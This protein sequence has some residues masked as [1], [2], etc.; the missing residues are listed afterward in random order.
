MEKEKITTNEA[1]EKKDKFTDAQN[2]VLRHPAGNLLVSASAG[3][4]KTSTL[5]EKIVRMVLAGDVK[6][7]NMLVVTFTNSASLELKEKLTTR[8]MES[9]DEKLIAEIDNISTSDIVT[10]D[11]FCIKVLREFG[12]TI[13]FNDNFS[14]ADESLAKFFKSQALDNIFA[15]HNKNLD[16]KFI[17]FVSQFFEDRKE[18][19]V[20]NSIVKLYNFLK[21]KGTG[22]SYSAMLDDFYK[23]DSNNPAIKYAN[24]CISNA[25]DAAIEL[26]EK[27]KLNAQI[28]GEEKLAEQLEVALAEFR[29]INTDILANFY[30]LVDLKLPSINADNKNDTAEASEIK[31]Q[32]AKTKAMFI[33]DL[34]SIL[35][36]SA[37][38][39]KFEQMQKD[40]NR[41]KASLEYVFDI[42]HEF[43]EEYNSIK[44]SH[45]ILDFNDI[46]KLALKILQDDSISKSIQSR[47][48]WIF[49]D[50]YQD[51]SDL[52]ENIV[53][54]ITNGCNLLMVGDLKQSIYRFRQAE[55]KIF[56]TKYN[57]YKKQ[58][59]ENKLI[60][61][62]TNFR[63]ENS[64]LQFNN[65]IFDK[66]YKQN[67]DDFEYKDNA[68]LEFGG[69][70]KKSTQNPQVSL[71]ILDKNAD[72]EDSGD[73]ELDSENSEI[74]D[75]EEKG[76]VYSVKDS[77]LTF[78][79]HKAIEK[80]AIVLANKIND[81]VGKPIYDAKAKRMRNI[82]Y[83]D[84][85]IL[86]RTKAGVVLEVREILKEAN[87]PVLAEYS[88]NIFK[89]YDMKILIDILSCIDN[90]NDDL[91]LLTALVNIGELSF[92]ELAE[93]KN[94]YRKEKFF[95]NAVNKYIQNQNDTISQKI[96]AC[97]DKL[98]FY[99]YKSNHLDI[100][101]L[102]NL[103][104]EKENFEIYFAANNY[105][106]EFKSHMHTFE[107][108]I[109]SIKDYDLS[110]FV[111]YVKTFLVNEE[112]DC[113]IKDGEDAVTITT[114][115]KS[116]G[117]EY[118]V[119]F[120]I[121][122]EKLFSNKSI[123]QKIL[124]DNDWGISM[125]SFDTD[126]H[127]SYDNIIKN[128]FKRKITDE[129]KKEQKRLLYVALT[130]AKNYLI[131]IGSKKKNL[132]KTL[133]SEY[134]ILHVNNYLDWI[135][136]SLSAE[137]I[138]KLCQNEQAIFD[139][140]QNECFEAKI[141]SDGNFVFKPELL[142]D[143]TM[144]EQIYINKKQFVDILS[145]KFYHSTLAKKSSVT[146]IMQEEE[147]Y[148]ISDF[149]FAKSDKPGDDDFLSIGT[150]YHKFMELIDF[151]DDKENL[152][153]QIEILKQLGKLTAHDCELVDIE[154]IVD[155]AAIISKLIKNGDIVSKER[156]FLSY[157]NA[158]E[159]SNTTEDSKVLIQGVADLI[160]EKEN[161]IYLI[162]YKTSRL[163]SE[164][165]FV[166]KYKT[167]LDI[168][169]K[170]I[171]SYFG[172]PVTKKL[173]YSFWLNKLIII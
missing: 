80:Q 15:K 23:L 142:K 84:I 168:Y 126:A 95:Y 4:G 122:A 171:Q 65:M 114:I 3:S 130:R 104:V 149:T 11:S 2:E 106:N 98:D 103:I 31:S 100:L 158:S 59:L 99:R 139:L 7:K 34:K 62:K 165:D 36:M 147:H 133:D 27:L 123:T 110:E 66:I 94:K 137:Q 78:K 121:G 37:K 25:K 20:R 160:I 33:A 8:L 82:S 55:P 70:A 29:S 85:A 128:I 45:K 92:K 96:L 119:V 49:I 91:P 164:Q 21:I 117:L 134:D 50:E 17:N 74:A 56:I 61:L 60:E 1:S 83:K 47:Y 54:K 132:L 161:E 170:S 18:E 156:Q 76:G 43:D 143:K 146:Q 10:F 120:L 28:Y 118:P 127:V 69:S 81:L 89:C 26:I 41:T 150:A 22:V 172:K 144:P 141:L 135:V 169:S 115:H 136:G 51:T 38:N 79:K 13:G 140:P 97:F 167:Q 9:D 155:A 166:K 111:N 77:C 67:I 152:L 63:S 40:L 163:N 154:K 46:E 6:L 101:Q 24:K 73:E 93:V 107:T 173:V 57:E 148:N 162:D 48:T 102:I 125:S 42:V 52:Q 58:T 90:Q 131:I 145:Q 71:L 30:N 116:K 112:Q 53:E 5:I 157:F 86:S 105:I 72:S 159:I 88:E 138:E 153:N 44:A 129:E 32:Y 16:D 151:C 108:C 109:E 19:N 35:P 14:V 39:L 12:Y 124:N 75:F 64:I 68:D 113:V 87:I